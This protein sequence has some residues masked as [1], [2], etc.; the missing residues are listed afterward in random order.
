ML[1]LPLVCPH[2]WILMSVIIHQFAFQNFDF[3]CFLLSL[4]L[5]WW[6]DACFRLF[7]LRK[8]QKQMHVLNL[9]SLGLKTDI[10][11][12]HH[13][14]CRNTK[15]SEKRLGHVIETSVTEPV[16]DSRSLILSII[17]ATTISLIID[18]CLFIIQMFR[19][20]SRTLPLLPWIIQ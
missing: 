5:F 1:L 10:I 19:C 11:Y 14:F 12:F 3:Y 16:L 8:G 18:L 7:T 9:Q 2:P 20:F 17:S 6:A 15:I 4:H 13:S